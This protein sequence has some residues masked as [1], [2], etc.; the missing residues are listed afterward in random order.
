MDTTGILLSGVAWLVICLGVG[1]FVA[2]K[3]A[4]KKKAS[5]EQ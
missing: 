2:I 5:K 3:L 4:A 1:Y